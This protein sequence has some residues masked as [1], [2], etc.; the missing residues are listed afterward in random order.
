MSKKGCELPRI[1]WIEE[2]PKRFGWWWR[3]PAKALRGPFP[4]KSEEVIRK[5]IW[6]ELERAAFNYEL[7]S[8]RSGRRKYL[9]GKR[10][11]RL[12]HEQIGEIM[13]LRLWKRKWRPLEPIRF[14]P[15][16]A[17]GWSL[18]ITW[19]AKRDWTVPR[20][21]MMNLAECSDRSICKAFQKHVADE[22][23]RL[24]IPAPKLNKGRANR[25]AGGLSFRKIEALDVWRRIPRAKAETTGYD[26]AEARSARREASTLFRQWQKGK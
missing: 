23:E 3:D 15:D 14:L 19:A 12:T 7:A 11:D 18:W 20:S 2:L 10:F 8:R 5:W 24:K 13:R 22:R 21:F 9:L 1:R 16:T 6:P 4:D 17:E 25:S 26:D